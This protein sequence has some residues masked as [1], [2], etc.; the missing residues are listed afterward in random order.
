MLQGAWDREN[1]MEDTE[2]QEGQSV[3]RQG[4]PESQG[5]ESREGRSY[6]ARP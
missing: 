6:P 1:G 5:L 2:E 4:Y 3:V